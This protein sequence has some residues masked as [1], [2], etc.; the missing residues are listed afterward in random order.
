MRENYRHNSLVLMDFR[1]DFNVVEVSEFIQNQ[2]NIRALHISDNSI[3]NYTEL[4]LP[5]SIESLTLLC[6]GDADITRLKL[7]PNL[8]MFTFRGNLNTDVL[9]MKFPDTLIQLR[10]GENVISDFSALKLPP[11]LEVF[12][13]NNCLI[14]DVSQLNLPNSLEFLILNENDIVDVSA[15]TLPRRLISLDL[16]QNQI[17]DISMLHLPPGLLFLVLTGNQIAD[18]STLVLP[19]TLVS[20]NLRH[21]P[22]QDYKPIAK[23]ILNIPS[24]TSFPLFEPLSGWKISVAALSYASPVLR[25][26][27]LLR[28]FMVGVVASYSTCGIGIKK[29]LPELWKLVMDMLIDYDEEKK[30]YNEMIVAENFQ[31]QIHEEDERG[32]SS[33]EEE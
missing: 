5:D 19:K 27:M 21:N 23:Q 16:S 32:Y 6:A 30:L 29:I 12:G 10:F 8:T 22:I 20:L 13:L 14:R 15:L 33:E 4:I 31:R 1:N 18:I 7:P 9:R 24:L 25:K 2:A 17:S 3:A 11:R 28:R 26:Y